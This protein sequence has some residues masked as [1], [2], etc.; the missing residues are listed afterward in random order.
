MAS[1]FARLR[2]LLERVA[3]A[4]LK[5][6]VKAGP[7][8]SKLDSLIRSAEEIASVGLQPEDQPL[9]GP[10]T[11]RHRLTLIVGLLLLGVSIYVLIGFLR[12]PAPLREA[13]DRKSTRL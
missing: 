6:D 2:G 9:P 8:K 12:K 3:F 7:K 10:T 4:G 1:R 11:L 13:A 5:P